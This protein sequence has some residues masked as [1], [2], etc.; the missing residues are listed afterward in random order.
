MIIGTT[1]QMRILKDLEMLMCFNIVIRV[2]NLTVPSE[3][4][5]VLSS[6]SAN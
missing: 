1:S 2:P 5:S 3:I 4:E 6:F